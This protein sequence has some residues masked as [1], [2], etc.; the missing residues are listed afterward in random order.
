MSFVCTVQ[1]PMNT[2][3]CAE[4]RVCFDPN[5]AIFDSLISKLSKANYEPSLEHFVLITLSCL[6]L[7]LTCLKCVQNY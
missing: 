5:K 7:W 1:Q 2:Q 6:Q 3:N 4:R